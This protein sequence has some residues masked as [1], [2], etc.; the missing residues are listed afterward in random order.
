MYIDFFR[1]FPWTMRIMGLIL[2]FT[3]G[4]PNIVLARRLP[5]QNIP[6]GLFNIKA[7]KVPAFTSYCF[8][9][10]IAYLGFYTGVLF[11]PAFRAPASAHIE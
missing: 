6:G 1:R 5:P 9:S 4:I 8:A 3:L 7:F 10:T 11:I 2:I